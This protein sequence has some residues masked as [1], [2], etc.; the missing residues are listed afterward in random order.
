[1]PN[2]SPEPEIGTRERLLDTAEELF[3]AHGLRETTMRQITAGAGANL[4]AVNYHF[5]SKTALVAEVFRRRLEPMNAER[6]RLLDEALARAG[7]DRPDLRAV[8][9]AFIVP[10]LRLGRGAG[11][12]LFQL[13]ARAHLAPD[14][15]LR[16]LVAGQFEDVA[17]RFGAALSLALPGAPMD[18]LFWRVFF[19]VGSM[20]H[21]ALNTA[22]LSEVTHGR[23]TAD[24]ED[25]VLARLLDFAVAGVSTA[26]HTTTSA[27]PPARGPRAP[28]ARP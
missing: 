26:A 11:Q 19:V 18:E 28:G 15:E 12:G 2:S 21:T 6:L 20:C 25:A 5:G 23:C 27:A 22:L 17:R 1:M 16:R 14:P 7:D 24:D 3:S 8:L 9:T 10:A 4:A 13:M